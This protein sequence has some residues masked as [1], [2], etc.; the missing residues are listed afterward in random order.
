MRKPA[1]KEEKKFSASPRTNLTKGEKKEEWVCPEC[2]VAY[3]KRPVGKQE[4]VGIYVCSPKCRQNIE[5]NLV[6]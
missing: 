1:K 5:K 6:W 3:D 4:Y 2:N